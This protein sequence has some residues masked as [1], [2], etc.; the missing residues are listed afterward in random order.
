MRVQVC[1]EIYKQDLFFFP[2]HFFPAP[3][4]GE[5]RSWWVMVLTFSLF[6]EAGSTPIAA[7]SS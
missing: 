4:A 2:F 5:R 1:W 3:E 7:S 6:T